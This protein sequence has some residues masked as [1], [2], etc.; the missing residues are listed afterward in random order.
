MLPVAAQAEDGSHTTKAQ[1]EWTERVAATFPAAANHPPKAQIEHAESETGGSSPAD[2]RQQ[3]A[4]ERH[5]VSGDGAAAWQLALSAA[6]GAS[7]TGLVVAAG[8]RTNRGRAALA[9]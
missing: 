9:G 6:A 8:R 3:P 7:V 5:D 1:V 4:R 2:V